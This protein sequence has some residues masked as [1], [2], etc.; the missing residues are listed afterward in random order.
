MTLP[1]S[2]I[3]HKGTGFLATQIGWQRPPHASKIS[4]TI[5]LIAATL[6]A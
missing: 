6:V 2:G 5:R 3:A 4:V 1:Y